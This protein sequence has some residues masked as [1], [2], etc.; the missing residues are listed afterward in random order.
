M[1]TRQAGVEA[2]MPSD[3]AKQEVPL[4]TETKES[5]ISWGPEEGLR[6]VQFR[7]SV[8]LLQAKASCK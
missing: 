7:L 2:E 3:V 5:R 4:P 1:S 8:R 6:R